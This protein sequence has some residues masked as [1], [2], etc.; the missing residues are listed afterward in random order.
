[1]TSTFCDTYSLPEQ[2]FN[3][4]MLQNNAFPE[5]YPQC[6]YRWGSDS[7]YQSSDSECSIMQEPENFNLDT[8][9]SQLGDNG[10][11]YSPAPYFTEPM[12][13]Q[14][15]NV[16]TCTNISPSIDVSLPYCQS[17][18]VFTEL[19]QTQQVS[20]NE[21]CPRQWNNV[22]GFSTT[23]LGDVEDYLQFS[24]IEVSDDDDDDIQNRVFNRHAVAAMNKLP[25]RKPFRPVQPSNFSR[26]HTVPV[27][28]NLT[29]RCRTG[30]S[31]S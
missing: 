28:F 12:S 22:S 13:P 11:E 24:D 20:R 27:D 25:E 2:C 23:Q 8:V 6:S 21:F 5:N 1:M 31:I 4:N 30:K 29:S 3:A 18:Q 16:P 19:S 15:V 9:F 10:S 7:A 17:Q 26:Y 14:E